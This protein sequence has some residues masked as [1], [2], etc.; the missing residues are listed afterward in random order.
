MTPWIGDCSLKNSIATSA[1]LAI[2]C[3]LSAGCALLSKSDPLTPRYFTLAGRGVDTPAMSS[4]SGTPARQVPPL[5]LGRVSGAAQLRE[6]IVY[7]SG[8]HEVG[9]YDDW[10]WT[11]RPDVYLRRVLVRTLFEERRF[12]QVISGAAPVLQAELLAFEQIRDDPQRVRMEVLITLYEGRATRL[13][14]TIG[15]ERPVQEASGDG[16]A[17]AVARAFEEA[18]NAG[19]KLAADHVTTILQP[20]RSEGEP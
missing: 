14:E 2:A 16:H 13:T 18:L 5:S 20:A 11:E 12:Q 10:R 8:D 6:R 4:S 19:V 15:I 7:R 1:V 3:M 17:N 9:Y